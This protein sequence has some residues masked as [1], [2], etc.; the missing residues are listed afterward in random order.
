GFINSDLVGTTT[1]HIDAKLD[2]LADNGG[3]TPTMALLTG[4]PAIGAGSGVN[5]PATDQR[6]VARPSQGPLDIGAFELPPPSSSSLSLSPSSLAAGTVGIGYN[7]AINAGGGNGDKTL[8]YTVT[9]GSILDGLTFSG[10]SNELDITGTPM[11]VGSF[12]FD[13]TATD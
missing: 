2:F 11:T 8:T 12:G 10:Q 4:S 7:Q 9:S 3:P 6:S 13:V 5:A 1:N